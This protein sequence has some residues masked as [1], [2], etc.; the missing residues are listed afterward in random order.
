MSVQDYEVFLFIYSKLCWGFRLSHH[1]GW[2][3]WGQQPNM[4]SNGLLGG[5][6][7]VGLRVNRCFIV[8]W[9]AQLHQINMSKLWPCGT[10][11][12]MLHTYGHPMYW[13]FSGWEILSNMLVSNSQA[14][15]QI[16]FTR[17]TFW[18]NVVSSWLL[19][20]LHF[21]WE[22]TINILNAVTKF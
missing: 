6:P 14:S 12:K 5:M 13:Q 7:Y 18:Y 1:V 21:I 17:S 16:Q 22:K 15:Y 20:F 4:V 11:V 10:K 8:K 3:F 2:R 9:E 19:Y